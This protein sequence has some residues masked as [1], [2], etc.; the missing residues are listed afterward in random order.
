M[1]ELQIGGTSAFYSSIWINPVLI[2]D[3]DIAASAVLLD[4]DGTLLDIAPKPDEVRVPPDLLRVLQKLCSM[5]GG[6]LALVSGRPIAD[7]DRIFAPL[8]L[9]CIGGHGAELRLSNQETVRLAPNLDPVL[10]HQLA[11]LGE[12]RPGI[13][14]EDKGY[15]I[16]LHY[17]LAPEQEPELRR[18]TEEICSAYLTGCE[19][20]R[21][22]AVIEIKSTAHNKGLAVRALMKRQPFSA[23]RPIFIGDD[24]T[25][26]PALAIMPEFEG[27]GFSVGREI[28]GVAGIFAGPKDVRN[29]LDRIVMER[30]PS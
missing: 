17:R 1:Q 20:L 10:R 22:K 14:V 9:C 16:A 5:T 4:V 11:A 7:L 21:G 2:D 18:S 29:W 15:S 27:L 30:A 12:G 13:V 28:E 19:I 8:R 6:A 23:R 25:D 3:I 26:E 24:V